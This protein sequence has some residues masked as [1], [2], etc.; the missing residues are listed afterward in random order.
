[1]PVVQEV[2]GQ[3]PDASRDAD[4]FAGNAIADN[5]TSVRVSVA[6]G[7]NAFAENGRGN[8]WGSGE[9]FDLDGDGIGDRPHR[10]GDPFA[11]LAAK[12]PVLETFAR[13][14]AARALSWAEQAFPVFDLPHVEDPF[15]LVTPPPGVPLTGR[16]PA[17]RRPLSAALLLLLAPAAAF[18][19][20]TVR[21][22]RYAA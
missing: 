1:M 16:S 13:T 4:T 19:A 17:E 20:G 18:V 10:A 3:F 12:R 15:P 21:V 22:R 11:A 7:T 8:Y 9:T 2:I 5:R 6:G 14:P